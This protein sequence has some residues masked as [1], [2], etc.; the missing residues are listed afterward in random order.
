MPEVESNQLVSVAA[1]LVLRPSEVAEA[2]ATSEAFAR[3][4]HGCTVDMP[5]GRAIPYCLLTCHGCSSG[6]RYRQRQRR[7]G[8]K[9]HLAAE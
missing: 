1:S 5:F 9:Q 4:L 7:H 6:W 3:W 8:K 2:V